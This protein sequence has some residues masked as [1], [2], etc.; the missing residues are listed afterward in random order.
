MT[1]KR[2]ILVA[3]ASKVVRASLAKQLAD[4]FEV[5]EESSGESAWQTL[6]LDSAIVA[7][8]SGLGLSKLDAFGLLERVRASKLSRLNRLPF[9][10]V[11]ST[12]FSDE[13]RRQALERGVTDFV[14]KGSNASVDVVV[15]ALLEYRGDVT[16]LRGL[17]PDSAAMRLEQP[18]AGDDGLDEVGVQ[19]DVGV[20]DIMG[21]LGELAGLCDT[22]RTDVEVPEGSCGNEDAVQVRET[23]E[24]YLAKNVPHAAEGKGVGV[25]AFGIDGYDDL[26]A[27]YG[28]DLAIRTAEKFSFML[29]RKIRPEDCIGQLPDGLLVIVAAATSFD[30]CTHFATRICK[31]MAA[32]QVSVRGQR[33]DLTVS[34]GVAVMPD[35]G[36]E[37][38][39]PAL[40][41][42]AH[43]RLAVARKA[44]GN[45]VVARPDYQG[46]GL[47]NCETFVPMLKEL[48]ANTDPAVLRPCLG[49]I[50]M[51]LMPLLRELDKSF[52]FGLPI[53][54]MNKRLWDRARAERMVT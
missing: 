40:L 8:V 9:F 39:G 46:S 11:V 18:P 41:Q 28:S 29:A 22:N 23:V 5:R 13:D 34:A 14:V 49:T 37:L 50:G 43:D 25:I 21:R 33:L 1:I 44:G 31:A 36:M 16:E 27:R 53:D 38:T 51:E 32:A 45:R 20:S 48:L 52:R 6:V 15:S 10:L 17:V 35:D 4:E 42:L 3:D 47:G 30:A 19:T 12:S 24:E 7:V 54:D 2:K 26:L